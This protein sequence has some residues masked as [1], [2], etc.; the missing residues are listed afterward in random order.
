LRTTGLKEGRAAVYVAFETSREHC[1]GQSQDL[2]A[3]GLGIA[4]VFHSS[5]YEK[6]G[7]CMWAIGLQRGIQRGKIASLFQRAHM[8]PD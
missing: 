4:R 3:P 1:G 7:C 5:L 6:A 8:D 2:T